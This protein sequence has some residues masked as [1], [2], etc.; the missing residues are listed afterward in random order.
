MAERAARRLQLLERLARS[1]APGRGSAARARKARRAFVR[2]LDRLP[3]QLAA[4]VPPV[5]TSPNLRPGHLRRASAAVRLLATGGVADGRHRDPGAGRPARRNCAAG[6]ARP[7]VRSVHQGGYDRG[8]ARSDVDAAHRPVSLQRLPG[9]PPTRGAAPMR[10]DVPHDI[11]RDVPCGVPRGVPCGVHPDVLP[12]TLERPRPASALPLPASGPIDRRAPVREAPGAE[13][14][15][16]VPIWSSA[17]ATPKAA[18]SASSP[19]S[20]QRSV[21]S[22]PGSPACRQ[23]FRSAAR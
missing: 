9:P 18:E 7:T 3:E 6:G 8:L 20:A 4:G 17:A 11:P 21:A 22:R 23:G 15:V 14:S 5:R 10:N 16:I 13:L 12:A 19:R 2:L 1:G